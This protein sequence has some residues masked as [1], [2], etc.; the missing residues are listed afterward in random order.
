MPWPDPRITIRQAHAS[1]AFG[2][3]LPTHLPVRRQ[4]GGLPLSVV[5]PSHGLAAVGF[6]GFLCTR[7]ADRGDENGGYDDCLHGAPQ[8]T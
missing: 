7:C 4:E 5:V 3:G 6:Q 8:W 1:I 2:T